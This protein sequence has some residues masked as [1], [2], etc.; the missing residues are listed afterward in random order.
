VGWS[1]SRNGGQHHRNF[2]YPERHNKFT[3]QRN[4]L[5]PNKI[6]LIY[7]KVKLINNYPVFWTDPNDTFD[8]DYVVKIMIR[9]NLIDSFYLNFDNDKIYKYDEYP[10]YVIDDGAVVVYFIIRRNDLKII[11]KFRTR[12][13]WKIYDYMDKLK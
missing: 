12:K 11:R 7:N 8:N 13:Y 3:P 1:T 2:H 9:N 10:E 6:D 4:S 5:D